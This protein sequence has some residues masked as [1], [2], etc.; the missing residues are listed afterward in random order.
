MNI[1]VIGLAASV[2]FVWL[3]LALTLLWL[4]GDLDGEQVPRQFRV[5]GAVALVWLSQV[6]GRLSRRKR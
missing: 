6:T 5:V 2:L 4:R 1:V 3:P